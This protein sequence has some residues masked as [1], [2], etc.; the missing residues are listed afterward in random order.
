MKL[1]QYDKYLVNIVRTD[2]LVLW[3]Q[4]ILSYSVDYAPMHFQLFL[5]LILTFKLCYHDS[6]PPPHVLFYQNQ[7]TKCLKL[8]DASNNVSVR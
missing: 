6:A 8:S 7:T 4:D 3:H 5:G 1:V 2:G